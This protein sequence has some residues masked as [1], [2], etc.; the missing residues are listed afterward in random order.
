MFPFDD[1]IMAAIYA[2]GMKRLH[3]NLSQVDFYTLRFNG[4]KSNKLLPYTNS[5]THLTYNESKMLIIM[6]FMAVTDF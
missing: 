6:A 4:T 3:T 1:V 2:L 5:K